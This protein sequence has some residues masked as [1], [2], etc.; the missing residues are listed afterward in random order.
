MEKEDM[1]YKEAKRRAL[2]Y[3]PDY[4]SCYE[5]ETA[6]HFIDKNNDS[7]GDN[8]IVIIK[9]NGKMTNFVDYIGE[10]KPGKAKELEF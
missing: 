1:T 6:Y 5:Y 4:D 2:E 9:E 10:Y 7:T 8:G 3:N